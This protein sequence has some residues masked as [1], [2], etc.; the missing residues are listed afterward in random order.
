MFV[1]KGTFFAGIVMV[2]LL[3][4]MACG[5]GSEETTS[6]STTTSTSTTT[7][8]TASEPEASEETTVGAEAAE[9][10]VGYSDIATGT[11]LENGH[12]IVD[13]V[14]YGGVYS[15]FGE[16]PEYGG[17]A[18]MS[19][20]RD[21]PG[22]DIMQTGGTIS[23]KRVSGS[24]YGD[25][26]LVHVNPLNVF[27]IECWL[28]TS[29]DMEQGGK[30]WTFNLRDDVKWHD[31]TPF[32]AEDVKY[33][34]ELTVTPEI[35]APGR[36]PA[37][38]VAD[39][40]DLDKVEVI[41]R[42]T[43]R[44]TLTKANPTW[45]EEMG[46][47]SDQIAHP[48]HLA[49]PF[50]DEGKFKLQP[51]DYGWVALGPF[52]FKSYDKGSVIKVRRSEVY[53]EK[54]EWGQQMPYLDGIDYVV[55]RD[56]GAMGS[57]FRA[58]RL[59]ETSRGTGHHLLPVQEEAIVRELGD[60]VYIG[61]VL[62]LGWGLGPNNG[63]PPWDSLEL[64]KANSLFFDRNELLKLAYGGPP[65]AVP[66]GAVFQ[67]GSPWSS[68]D[69]MTW[70]GWNP[71]TKKEDQAAAMKILKDSG[72]EGMTANVLCRDVYLHLCE[73]LD[74][75]WR[76]MGFNSV[77]EMTEVTAL[78]E[79]TPTGDFD[80]RITSLGSPSFP[81]EVITA[82][83]SSNPY[84]GYHHNDPRVDELLDLVSSTLDHEQRVKYAREFE[85]YVVDDMYYGIPWGKEIANIG[86]KSCFK[87]VQI[88]Q[89]TVHN[90]TSY[91]S[92][93]LDRDEC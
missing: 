14:A 82:W 87:N 83:I 80:T 45:L 60:K 10:A 54:D 23:L 78:S 91:A 27:E 15:G 84:G 18:I 47:H 58:G 68:P 3:L 69:L 38:N 70:P 30:V 36:T 89:T 1:P 76:A 51:I 71:A 11:M 79:R 52:A 59:H 7:E 88:P 37:R 13:G 72:F 93:W 92:A 41:D 12:I 33:W 81:G 17:I 16:K 32:T 48:K 40:K 8:S 90:N 20:R 2:A 42:L 35:H 66:A 64:R 22:T 19:H 85:K 25:G 74:G 55:M 86:F 67:P 43:V 63:K 21:L 4:A 6:S 49:Q 62:Y 39:Y 73:A 28:C 26:N 65:A 53:F 56:R 34:I 50:F 44:F 61:R 77:I 46:G 29:W 57:A 24:L 5:G 9:E 75:Q 31:G